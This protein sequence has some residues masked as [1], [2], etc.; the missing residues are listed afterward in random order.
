[1]VE[2]FLVK[3]APCLAGRQERQAGKVMRWSMQEEAERQPG[4]PEHAGQ[5]YHLLR[6]LS[7]DV[8]GDR[9]LSVFW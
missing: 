6:Q 9:W 2:W 4:T 3:N 7:Y 1:M 5:P 8:H